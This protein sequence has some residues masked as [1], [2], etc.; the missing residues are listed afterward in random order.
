MATFL[1]NLKVL[2][3]IRTTLGLNLNLALFFGQCAFFL[4]YSPIFL[5]KSVASSAFF[6]IPIKTL[7]QYS[8]NLKIG[9]DVV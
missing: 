7:G 3:K 6:Q 9:T 5:E 1:A 4:S 8:G 2:L